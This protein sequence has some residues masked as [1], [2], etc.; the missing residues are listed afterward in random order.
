MLS[1]LSKSLAKRYGHVH[2][3]NNSMMNNG[4]YIRYFSTTEDGKPR[5]LFVCVA[6]SCRSQLAEALG[7][8][9]LSDIYEV[10][11][12]GSTPS[13]PNPLAIEFLKNKGYDTSELYSKSYADIPKP[14]NIAIAL[15]DE[16]DMECNSYFDTSILERRCW[17]QKDPVKVDGSEGDKMEVM[18]TVYNNIEK[19]MIE[20]KEQSLKDLKKN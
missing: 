9:Y 12:A 15:C 7:R 16:G 20:F 17:S 19:L 1:T 13:T 3:W 18:E 11:S 4:Y 5:V 10:H 8:K 2:G 14:V 6:N